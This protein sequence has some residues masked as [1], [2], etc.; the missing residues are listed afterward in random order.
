MQANT[1]PEDICVW[2]DGT[3]CFLEDIEDYTWM[4]DDFSVLKVDSE[5]WH[6]FDPDQPLKYLEPQA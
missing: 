2:P 6:T 4:S 5:E 3:W 1:H